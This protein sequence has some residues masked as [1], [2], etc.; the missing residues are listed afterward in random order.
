MSPA[1]MAVAPLTPVTVTRTDEP[2]VVPLPSCPRWLRPQH[3]TAP[4]ATNAHVW[5]WPASMAVAPLIPVT[6]TGTDELV[7]LPL[8]S[9][10]YSL[11]PQHLTA[12]PATIAQL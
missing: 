12:P 7:L 4:P 5:N 10:P 2:V 3:L 1:L 9:C 8:P 6:V 11:E